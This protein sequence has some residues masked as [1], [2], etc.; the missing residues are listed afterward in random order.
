MAAK[1]GQ[2]WEDAYDYRISSPKAQG[3]VQPTLEIAETDGTP[4]GF[5]HGIRRPSGRKTRV[6]LNDKGEPRGYRLKK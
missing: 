4:G 3:F 5:A 6:R 2:V 1:A